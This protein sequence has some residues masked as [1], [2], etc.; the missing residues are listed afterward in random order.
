MPAARPFIILA[1]ISLFSFPAFA[2]Q[3]ARN[4][5]TEQ[6]IADRLASM[7]PQALD[8]FQRATA[9]MD[10]GN[11]QEAIPLFQQVA[12]PNLCSRRL[13]EGNPSLPPRRATLHPL[14]ILNV[15]TR[16]NEALR[17][18]GWPDQMPLLEMSG[19]DGR[20]KTSVCHST[21]CE[22]P[23]IEWCIL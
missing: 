20:P 14:C 5:K 2:Q 3:T 18:R 22:K 13:F 7:A 8:L 10:S 17:V 4:S 23:R 19:A 21:D 12:H 6:A 11:Y 9:A 1:A 15:Y 16:S